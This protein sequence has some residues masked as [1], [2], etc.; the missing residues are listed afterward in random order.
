[1]NALK[2]CAAAVLLASATIAYAQEPAPQDESAGEGMFSPWPVV[3]YSGDLASRS[4]MTGDWGDLRNELAENGITFE[5]DVLNI[6]Q[7]NARGGKSTTSAWRYSGST[8][9]TLKLDT[10]RAN[11]WPGGLITF[12][13]RTKYGRGISEKVGGPVNFDALIATPEECVTT[14]S[15]WYLTQPV[16]KQLVFLLGKMDGSRLADQNWFASNERSQFMHM[17]LRANPMV[18]PHAPYTAL[19]VGVIWM[20]TEWLDSATIIWDTNDRAGRV[21]FDT[22]FHSPQGTSIAQ[23]FNL[24]VKP[25]GMKGRY[26]FGAIYSKKKFTV[27]DFG[28]PPFI[29]TPQGPKLKVDTRPDDWALYHNFSQYIYSEADDPNQGV[30]LFGRFGWSTGKANPFHQFYSIG[31]SGQG[32]IPTRDNDTCGLGYF[33]LNFSD[34]LPKIL[35]IN[36]SQGIEMYYNIEITPWL[37]VSPDLQIIFSPGGNTDEDTAIVAGIRMRMLL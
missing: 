16:S 8:E 21:G 20:P 25:F 12:R 29:I 23:E 27:L 35:G 19:T 36:A 15:E 26:V 32:I 1:M 22:A 4:A 31:V 2:F 14:F 5:I 37:H 34:G 28:R 6:F 30:G 24:N 18:I 7:G 11:L 10:G 13:G 33:Y 3:N 17:G 9:Y